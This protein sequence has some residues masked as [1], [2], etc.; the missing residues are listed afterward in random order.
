MNDVF[1]CLPLAG[2]VEKEVLLIHGGIGENIQSVDQLRNIQKPIRVPSGD[3]IELGQVDKII[4]D[5]L[6]SDPTENDSVLGVHL[7]PRGQGACRYGPDR[8]ETFCRVN[9]LQMIIR[10]HECVQRG[11]EYFAQGRLITV[12]SATSY[13]NQYNNDA[14]MIVLIR[15]PDDLTTI[16]EHPLVLKAGH[17]HSALG[18]TTPTLN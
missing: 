16:E 14:A 15:S 6:W 5:A 9:K 13:C 11:Y 12:F 3:H 8:V 17:P 4:L 18:W 2:L 10:A 7:S 1:D